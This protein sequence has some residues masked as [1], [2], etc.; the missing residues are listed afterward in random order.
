MSNRR[1]A[2]LWQDALLIRVHKVNKNEP[3]DFSIG[4][5][6]DLVWI[7]SRISS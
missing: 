7:G 2:V 4:H 6:E 5:D 3:L 1:S